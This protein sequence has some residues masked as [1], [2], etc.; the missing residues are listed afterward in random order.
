ML[1]DRPPDRPY[2][3]TGISPDRADRLRRLATYASVA[4]ALTLVAVKLLTW[5]AT[6]SVSLLASV[7][8]SA[9]DA[10]AS[11]V[12]LVGVRHAMRPA[13]L[14]HRFGHGKAEPVAALLQAA[15]IAG[16][17]LILASEALSRLLEPRPIAYGYLGMAVMAFAILLTGLLVLFQRHVIRRT[18]SIA[19]S[20]DSLH[21]GGD[22]V[23]NLAVIVA[24][25]LTQITGA[26]VLFQRHVIRRTGSIAISA[27]SLHYGGDL[28]TNLAVIVALALTEYTGAWF[29][30]P[31]F[32]LGIVAFLLFYAVRLG[33]RA[34]DVLMD[35]ELPEAARAHIRRIVLAHPHTRGLHDLRTR[36][37]GA[38]GEFIELHL[39]L[40]GGLTLDEAHDITDEVERQLTRAFPNAEVIL[41][42]EPAGIEDERLDHRLVAGR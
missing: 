16:S 22:L 9:V 4:V 21:Y 40:D 32:A 5:L 15:F 41:H 28:V 2:A 35:R 6:G 3:A 7:I 27:D 33:R 37:S 19:I 10:V 30:D 11:V 14:T 17:A 38:A 1:L 18:G 13:D 42:Q 34:L 24:L 25:A 29:I 26:L 20:A 8:D 12:T 31:L 39:E 36:S 23:T